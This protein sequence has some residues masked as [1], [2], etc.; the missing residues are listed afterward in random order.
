MDSKTQS[1]EEQ[2]K[3]PIADSSRLKKKKPVRSY[4][5]ISDNN[6]NLLIK[7]VYNM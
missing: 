7:Y 3:K 4:T 6:R 2:P 1:I 5:I